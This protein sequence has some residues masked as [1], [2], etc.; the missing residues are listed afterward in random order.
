MKVLIVFSSDEGSDESFWNKL[1][2][3]KNPTNVNCCGR[4]YAFNGKNKN[5]CDN[6]EWIYDALRKE[7]ENIINE[8]DDGNEYIVLLHTQDDDDLQELEEVCAG[9]NI[10]M[11]KR[12]S[13]NDDWYHDFIKKLDVDSADSFNRLWRKLQE[14][15]TNADYL[16]TLFMHCNSYASKPDTTMLFDFFANYTDFNDTNVWKE[17]KAKRI[18]EE[19]DVYK[20][21]K[22]LFE[23]IKDNSVKTEIVISVQKSLY[24]VLD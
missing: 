9:A 14:D 15:E 11:F 23:S 21:V 19:S 10:S 4:L 5:Y 8:E 22:A 1:T 3:F 20:N 17:L 12:F 16:K 18:D 2:G 13:T 24:G 6:E 7:T